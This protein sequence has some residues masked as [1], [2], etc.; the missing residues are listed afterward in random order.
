M[1]IN[2]LGIGATLDV[3]HDGNRD[4]LATLVSD[5]PS[6][7]PL[8]AEGALMR[9]EAGAAAEGVSVNS[10][11]VR[12]LERHSSD[13]SRNNRVGNRLHGYGTT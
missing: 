10:F 5:D 11:I 6:L 3:K 7:A 12:V 13:R 4:V 8:I 1:R 2:R 9:L